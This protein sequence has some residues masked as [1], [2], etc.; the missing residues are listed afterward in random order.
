[1]RFECNHCSKKFTSE[2]GLS[3]HNSSV[4]SGN[5]KESGKINF[6]KYV[7]FSMIALI[8]IFS[9][10]TVYSYSQRAGEYDDF[11][12]C[13]TEKGAVVY[14]NDFCSFTNKQLNYFGNSDKYLDYVKCTENQALCNEKGVTVTPTW[15]IDGSM[16]KSVQTFEGLATISGCEI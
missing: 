1:M 8:F 15:E 4:H 11:A 13:L 6:K 12:K 7:L 2:H 16:Y 14:G 5:M 9:S 3:Q 10:M